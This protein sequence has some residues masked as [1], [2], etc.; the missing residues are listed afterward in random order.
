MTIIDNDTVPCEH[1]IGLQEFL[2][3]SG[4]EIFGEWTQ[5]PDGWVNIHCRRCDRYYRVDLH[6]GE[7]DQALAGAK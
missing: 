3:Q 7:P 2:Q 5:S 6:E 4:L 1:L